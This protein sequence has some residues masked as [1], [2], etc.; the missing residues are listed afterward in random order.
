MPELP[1]L[2]ISMAAYMNMFNGCTSLKLAAAQDSDYPNEFRI[3]SSGT[4][5][6]QSNSFTNM[7]AGTGGTFTGTPTVNTSCYTPN[8]I[9]PAAA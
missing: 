3:P 9:V 4:G 5:S 6:A 1:A 2:T 7:F 8:A